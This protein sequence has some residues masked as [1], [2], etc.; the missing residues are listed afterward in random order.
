MA[1]L[2]F[3]L[4]PVTRTPG[5][6]KYFTERELRPDGNRLTDGSTGWQ[7]PLPP[8]CLRLWLPEAKVGLAQMELSEVR[9]SRFQKGLLE[10][11]AALPS[12]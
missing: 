8:S 5:K 6:N 4:S 11:T 2:T 3:F 7:L 10:Q 12:T 1:S 9:S